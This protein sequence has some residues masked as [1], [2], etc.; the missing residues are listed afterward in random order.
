MACEL[1]SRQVQA[2]LKMQEYADDF[3][4][5]LSTFNAPRMA[6]SVK[7]ITQTV[8]TADNLVNYYFGDSF[9]TF[10]AFSKTGTSEQKK[11]FVDSINESLKELYRASET[12][13][14]LGSALHSSSSMAKYIKYLHRLETAPAVVSGAFR[15]TV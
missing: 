14:K 1:K 15:S 13:L 2:G 4:K 7:D 10:E 6:D 9:E 12:P 8:R 3:I 11:F 5:V